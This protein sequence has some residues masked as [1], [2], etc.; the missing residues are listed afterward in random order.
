[1]GFSVSE[2][3]AHINRNFIASPNRYEVSIFPG[4]MI[5]RPIQ[6]DDIVRD[7]M[8][9]CSAINV[10]GINIGFTPEKRQGIGMI[11]NMPNAK[12]YS[13]IN[14]TFYESEREIER[15][16]FVDWIDSIYDKDTGRFNFYN[17]YVRIVQIDQFNKKGD[18]VYRCELIDCYPSNVGPLDRGYQAG[19]AAPQFSVSMQFYEMKETFYG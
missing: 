7:V 4:V 16:Y 2:I 8:F 1:M 5:G 13:E 12:A 3:I 10:P 11:T 14:L 15:K 17:D 19:D 9:N 18:L 6:P